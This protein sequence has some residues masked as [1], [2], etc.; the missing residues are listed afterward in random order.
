MP[1]RPA[2]WGAAG[3]VAAGVVAAVTLGVIGLDLMTGS[4]LALETP[5]GL[6][7]LEAGRFYGLGNNG[8]VIY[9]ASGILCAAWLGGRAVRRGGGPAGRTGEGRGAG[10]PGGGS[11][12]R[13]GRG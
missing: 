13:R 2:G 10:R 4:H 8:L 11:V 7:V 9:G 12:G 3:G 6:H 1:L 5:F